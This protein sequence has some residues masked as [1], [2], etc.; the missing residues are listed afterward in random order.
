MYNYLKTIEILKKDEGLSLTP[1]LD[2]VG[3]WTIGYGS[4][5]LFGEK[6]VR[7]TGKTEK[8]TRTKAEMLLIIGLHKAILIASQ[9]VTN[10][11]QL[12]SARQAVLSMMAYQM[13]SKNL[14]KFKKTKKLIEEN[15]CAE[16][17]AD[18]MH[19]SKW[20]NVDSPERAGRII[21]MYYQDF[22]IAE[23]VVTKKTLVEQENEK[24]QYGVIE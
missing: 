15:A 13:G 6:M 8:I 4:T 1:Y 21:R 5:F 9:F 16:D 17:I 23:I 22:L 7:V 3:V 12:S 11:K 18:E 24:K 19:N 14:N 20:S 10:Y 2:S